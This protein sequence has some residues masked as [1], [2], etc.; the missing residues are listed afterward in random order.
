MSPP[1]CRTGPCFVQGHATHPDWHMALALAAAQIE[2]QRARLAQ[3]AEPALLTPTLG[4]VYFTDAYAAEAPALLAELALRWPG[5]AWVGGSGLTVLATG[6]QYRNE[7]A[8]ALMLC[9]LP[10]AAFQV[11]HGR[12]PLPWGPRAQTP[13]RCAEWALVHADMGLL[14]WPDLLAEL[15]ERT[16]TGRLVGGLVHGTAQA[17]QVADG[18]W[19]GGLSGIAFGAEVGVCMRLVHGMRPLGPVRRVTAAHGKQVLALD[20]E[21]ALACLLQDLGAPPGLARPDVGVLR[22]TAAMV[23]EGG[24]TLLSK[25]A[26]T[27]AAAYRPIVGFDRGGQGVVIE[28]RPRP[29][30]PLAFAQVDAATARRDLAQACAALRDELAEPG[31]TGVRHVAGVLYYA[32]DSRVPLLADGATDMQVL[33]QALGDVPVLGCAVSGEVWGSRLHGFCGVLLAFT[34]AGPAPGSGAGGG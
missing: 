26:F 24:D 27:E 17:V 22:T 5:V 15:A 20:G 6:V 28:D 31:P 12:Q 11:F 4:F 18:I 16:R 3:G 30:M 19:S 10:A 21:P 29:G 34:R 7:P 23:A 8:L 25:G 14:Q 13:D 1:T 9:D 2:G 32:C 33:S